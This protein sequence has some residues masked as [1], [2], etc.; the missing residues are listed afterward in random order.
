MRW[1]DWSAGAKGGVYA[2]LFLIIILIF[3]FILCLI[4]T[5]NASCG[6]VFL[7]L[8]IWPW[9]SVILFI[10]GSIIGVSIK[11]EMNY[12]LKGGLIGFGLYLII[13]TISM[14]LVGWF[15]KVFGMLNPANFLIEIE[16]ISSLIISM[17]SFFWMEI[18]S[19]LIELLFWI[20][21]GALIGWIVGKIKSKHDS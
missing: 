21:I 1:K 6:F 17:K 12:A 11:K 13:L 3:Q 2:V 18:L 7:G 16:F 10:G 9:V 8:L 4:Q 20:L 19:N 15:G 5:R 14:T